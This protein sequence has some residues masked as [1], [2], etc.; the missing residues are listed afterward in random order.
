MESLL[1]LFI[2]EPQQCLW[3]LVLTRPARLCHHQHEPLPG[4]VFLMHQLERFGCKFEF[5]RQA[6]RER[7]RHGAA[8]SA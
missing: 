4:L 1:S 2:L 7:F 6:A 5:R 8:L 3:V